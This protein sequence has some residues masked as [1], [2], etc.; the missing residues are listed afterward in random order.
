MCLHCFVLL[1]T[2]S[3]YIVAYSRVHTIARVIKKILFYCV[4]YIIY[5][6]EN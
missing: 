3:H 6:I 1:F 2:C 5:C 4:V